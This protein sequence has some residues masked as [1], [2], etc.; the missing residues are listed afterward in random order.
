MT[1]FLLPH[2]VEVHRQQG[3]INSI[4][5][6]WVIGVSGIQR[7]DTQIISLII[8]IR[9][10]GFLSLRRTHLGILDI[11]KPTTTGLGG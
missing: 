1:F 4:V 8:I 6:M 10:L 7:Q 5:Q 9:V 2:A 11:T 3:M